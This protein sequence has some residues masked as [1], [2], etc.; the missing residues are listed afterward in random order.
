VNVLADE[1]SIHRSAVLDHLN[2]LQCSSPLPSA[3]RQGRRDCQAAV[4]R[5]L[6]SY[7]LGDEPEILV[8]LAGGRGRA[9]IISNACDQFEDRLHLSGQFANRLLI[10]A[11]RELLDLAASGFSFES[12]ASLCSCHITKGP[13]SGI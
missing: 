10:P 2:P 9:A 5:Y 7:R 8:D 1:F 3:Q 11:A 6:N 4:Q 13:R 12:I